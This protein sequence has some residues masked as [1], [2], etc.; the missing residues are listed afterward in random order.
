MEKLQ[1]KELIIGIEDLARK[2]SKELESNLKESKTDIKV[3]YTTGIDYSKED[4]S[5]ITF[6]LFIYPQST[7]YAVVSVG[8]NKD[9]NYLHYA[10]YILK[11]ILQGNCNIY[12]ITRE[13]SYLKNLF[14]FYKI[15]EFYIM[16]GILY[17]GEFEIDL[18]ELVEMNVNLK[19]NELYLKTSEDE[20]FRI[21]L[22]DE[23]MEF[24]D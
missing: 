8:Y 22:K 2:V 1:E 11:Q 13:E 15:S 23:T 3:T 6:R 21:N 18:S 5:Y 7:K 10:I 16:D 20:E 12:T 4:E 19:N 24:L 14:D 17:D 9:V